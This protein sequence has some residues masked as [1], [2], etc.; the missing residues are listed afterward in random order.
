[1]SPSLLIIVPCFNEQL[2][3][4]NTIKVLLSEVIDLIDSGLIEVVINKI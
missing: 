4:P 2:A 3:L 1:M